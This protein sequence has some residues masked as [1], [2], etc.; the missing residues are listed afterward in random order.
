MRFGVVILLPLADLKNH[1]SPPVRSVA[2]PVVSRRDVP[3]CAVI[4]AVY[5]LDALIVFDGPIC[6]CE[7]TCPTALLRA[8]SSLW[9]NSA[10]PRGHG[11]TS[12]TLTLSVEIRRVPSS[13]TVRL[14][15]VLDFGSWPSRCN[16]ECKQRAQPA[17]AKMTC[18]GRTASRCG[19]Y[20]HRRA[21]CRARSIRSFPP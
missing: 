14:L 12:P 3:P 1:G 17:S 4:P 10:P 7:L 20:G 18:Q 21:S 13:P 11:A 19:H 9:R 6:F 15:V 2:S 5:M 8:G 16:R